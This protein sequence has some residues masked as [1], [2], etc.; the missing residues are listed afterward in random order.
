MNA[1][2][3]EGGWLHVHENVRDTQV[4]AWVEGLCRRLED[5]ASERGAK[6]KATCTH[7]ERVKSYAPHVLHIVADIHMQ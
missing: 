6:W 2:R 1:L 3:P 5:L 4:E 7:V